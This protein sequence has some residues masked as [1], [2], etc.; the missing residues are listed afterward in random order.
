MFCDNCGKESSN[1]AKFCG[2]CG[3][4][5]TEAASQS[6]V[7]KEEV[8]ATASTPVATETTQSSPEN[9]YVKQGKVISKMYGGFFLASLKAPFKHAKTIQEATMTNGMIAFFLFSLLLP[10]ISYTEA[11]NLSPV[12]VPFGSIVVSPTI[13]I[14]LSL[15]TMS[16]VILVSLKLMQVNASYQVLVNRLGSLLTLPIAL[17]SA[18]FLFSLISM[19]FLSMFLLIPVLLIVPIAVYGT[20]FSYDNH[21][22]KGLDPFYGVLTSMIGFAII[23]MIVFIVAIDSMLNSI[24]NSVPLF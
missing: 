9:D 13:V 15:L 14:F 4:S 16:G 10:L 1:N 22:T 3:H 6:H 11:R 23:S 8:A 17:L 7:V 20:I 19:S 24:R 21:T 2:G 18:S 5:F 12:N